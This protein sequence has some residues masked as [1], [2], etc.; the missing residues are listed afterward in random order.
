MVSLTNLTDPTQHHQLFEYIQKLKD[1]PNG[2]R[3]CIENIVT[4]NFSGVEEHFVFLQVIESY[5]SNHYA[6]DDKGQEIIRLWMSNWMQTL[7]AAEVPPNYLSNKMAQL[8]A[9]VFAAD[10]PVRWPHF[11]HEVFLHHLESPNVVVFFLRTLLAIDTEVVDREIQRTKEV[12]DRN[13]QIK[14]AMRDLCIVDVAHEWTKILSVEGNV[15]ARELCLDAIACYV[16]WISIE[17]I[18]NDTMIPLII[19]CLDDEEISESAV[20]AIC[21][22]IEKG[23]DAQKKF[24]LVSALCVVLQQAGSLSINAESD[25]DEV[26]RNGIL[27]SAIGCALIECHNRFDKDSELS[28]RN[29]CDDL[30][31]KTL[32]PALFTL[33][34][35]DLEAS[36]TVIEFLREFVNMLKGEPLSQPHE[37]FLI[38]LIR[39]LVKRYRTPK[40]IDLEKDGENEVEFMEYRKQLRSLMSSVGTLKPDLIVSSLGPLVYSLCNEWASSEVRQIEA[41]LSLVYSLAEIIQSSFLSNNDDISTRAKALI[42]QVLSSEVTKSGASVVSTTFFEIVCR[43]DRI[44]VANPKPLRSI[45][46]AFVDSLTHPSARVRARIVYLFCRFVKAHRQSFGDCVINVLLRLAPMLAVEM[47]VNARFSEDDQMFLYEATSTL[48]VFGSLGRELKETYMNELAGSLLQK[49]NDAH[50]QLSQLTNEEDIKKCTHYMAN[51]IGYSSRITKTFSGANTMASCNCVVIFYEIMNTYLEKVPDE[52][53]EMMDA[54]RQY[55][56]RM[57]VS[58]DEQILPSL[59]AIFN[60]FVTP[61]SNLKNLNDFL[62]LVQQMFSK[63]KKRLIDSGLNLRAL[64]EIIWTVHST[65]QSDPTDESSTRNICYLNRSYLQMVSSICAN[66]LLPLIV[67]CGID[68]MV[69]LCASLLTFCSCSD[70]VAQ[71]AALS[72]VSKLM[73]GCFSNGSIIFAELPIWEQA[74]I[75]ALQVP[76]SERFDAGDAQSILVQ[77]EASTCLQLLRFCHAERFDTIVSNLLPAEV[78]QKTVEY[79]SS[80][81]GKELDKKMDELFDIL[82]KRRNSV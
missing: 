77:H 31:E 30:L 73:Y 74:I 7:S 82:R 35:E 59:S 56:H 8:F 41:V 70:T 42:L 66:D 23:M 54:L 63:L 16:D 3:N 71:K 26:M 76:L 55:L 33:S 48:I 27:L 36:E 32:P 67:N 20:R 17:L 72:A 12:F 37:A 47:D 5:L 60:K 49:F 19:G 45:L 64:F 22:I 68:F 51:I 21:A 52:N 81:K 2:W 11:M 34:H 53:D 69:Q 80:V 38:E 43:Y 15:K 50:N 6:K 75:T 9:L 61:K 57:V 58:L 24:S 65:Y 78:A 10:F 29:E 62:I 25:S 13:T 79:L 1:D 4:G 18:A 44:L 28:S 46:E 39:L 40:D 14:D